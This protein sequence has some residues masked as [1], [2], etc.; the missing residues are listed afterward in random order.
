MRK[1]TGKHIILI[2]TYANPTARYCDE[3]VLVRPGSDGAL[4]LAM[5]HV[6]ASEGLSDEAWLSGHGAGYEEFLKNLDQYT[7]EWA[8]EITGVWAETIRTLAYV[9]AQANAPAIILGSGNSR[10]KNGGMN[11]RLI[12]LL[13]HFTG[14]WKKPGGG[15]CGCTPVSGAYVDMSRIARPE[16]REKPGRRININQIAS[17]LALTGEDVVKSLYVYGCNPV[18]SVSN[19]NGMIKGLM[20]ED[21]FTVVHERFMTDTAKYADIILPAT[22]SVEQ[23][24]IYRAYG[25]CTLGAGKKLIDPPGECKSNWDTFCLLAKG[26]GYTEDYFSMTEDDILEDIL[27][28][29]TPAVAALPEETRAI[30]RDGG[31][32]SMPFADH[33]DIRTPEKKFRFIDAD[34]PVPLASYVPTEESMYPL[35]LVAAPGIESVNTIFHDR[36]DLMEKRGGETGNETASDSVYAEN[37]EW[38][39]S[40]EKVDDTLSET[41]ISLSDD[42]GESILKKSRGVMEL[43]I[44]PDTATVRGIGNG[45]PIRAENEYGHAEFVAHL[46]EEILPDTVVAVGVWSMQDAEGPTFEALC[47]EALSDMGEA[48]TLNENRV[49]VT[50]E[51]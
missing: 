26:M 15:L 34:A 4:A 8:E 13:S 41:G 10:H 49:E 20:R 51:V 44:H 17:A 16:F 24:D 39:R 31:S 33:T 23:N 9:Y 32:V 48:T 28:H 3:V 21:L 14:A 19:Q 25:Y 35:H 5:M 45:D 27:N 22:F 12:T 40:G 47:G 36:D 2:D 1:Q 6:L 37:H 18:N 38:K 11:V 30:L 50:A 29:P 7:P 42:P 43:L 46:T